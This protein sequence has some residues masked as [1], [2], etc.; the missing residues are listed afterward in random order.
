MNTLYHGTNNEFDK[1]DMSYLGKNG[2][3]L[4]HGIYLTHDKKIA[5]MYGDKIL[6]C[7]VVLNK[8]L[9]TTELTITKEQFESILLDVQRHTDILSNYGEFVIPAL[10]NAFDTTFKYAN[11]DL[12]IYNELCNINGDYL[13]V[14]D[15]FQKL[16][17]THA[18]NHKDL[19]EYIILNPNNITIK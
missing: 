14:M 3:A 12:D 16:G 11:N 15:A 18:V 6:T 4:G 2:R 8:E 13:E 7:D 9:S 1:F 17:Y 10:K 19:K 5:K